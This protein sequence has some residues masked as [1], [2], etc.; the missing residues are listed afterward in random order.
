MSKEAAA[1]YLAT[2]P[3]RQE[4]VRLATEA[5]RRKEE[6][7]KHKAD[8]AKKIQASIQQLILEAEKIVLAENSKWLRKKDFS[9]A[10]ELYFKAIALGSKE[11]EQKLTNLPS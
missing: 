7:A 3:L 2:V 10:R 9:Q 8:E 5:A 11:A 4:R 6:E 1:G